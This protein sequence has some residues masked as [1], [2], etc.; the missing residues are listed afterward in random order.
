FWGFSLNDRIPLSPLIFFFVGLIVLAAAW[1]L[2]QLWRRDSQAHRWLLLTGLHFGLLC[3]IPLLRFVTSGRLGQTAQGRHIL[4]P[5]AAAIV[6]LL[7]WGWA[8]AFPQP[9]RQRWFFSAV[10]AMMI[11]WSGA[12][13]Y[14]LVAQPP[15][16]LPMRTVAYA[17]NWLPESVEQGQFGEGIELVSYALTPQPTAGRLD[18][19]LAW[20]SLGL[21]NQNYLLSLTL[22]DAD[23]TP[24]SYWRGYHGAGHI[25]TLAWTPGDTIFDRLALPL[26][27]LPSGDYRLRVQVLADGVPLPLPTGADSLTLKPIRL[28]EATALP[29]P[30][31]LTHPSGGADLPFAIWQADGPDLTEQPHFRY[32]HTI[33]IVVDSTTETPP[34]ALVDSQDTIWPPE[35]VVNGVYLFVIG[36]RWP[37]GDYRLAVDEAVQPTPLLFVDNGRPRQF[38]VPPDMETPLAANFANQIFLA[39]YTLPQR[40]VTAGSSLPIT[41]YWQAPERT[42]QANF[43]QFNN[44]LDS[45]G[46]LR[47]GYDR[48]PLE[49]YSTLLWDPGEVVVDGYAVPVDP[50]APPGEYYLDVGYYIVVGGSGVNL[51]L[52][53]DGAMSDTTSISVGPIEVVA[54]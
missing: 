34:L 22:V 13:L 12:H 7:V 18:V 43:I 51:P 28:D 9:N 25:P 1:G 2:W 16:L 29:F 52:V 46:N 40:T 31:R 6:A 42:P 5:A 3:I 33:A 54:P 11:I 50:D 21:V 35:R 30:R 4:I 8:A 48:L 45:S 17:A 37:I 24:V 44:L 15:A 14:P 53:I 39:G 41:F 32:P 20:R 27:H 23:D 47:G 26:P 36:S 49:D 38:T 10:V 19:E